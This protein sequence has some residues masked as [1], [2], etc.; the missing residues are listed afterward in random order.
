MSK[1]NIPNFSFLACLEV[2]EKSVVVD[3]GRVGW[4]STFQVT[5]MSNFNLSFIECIKNTSLNL[6]RSFFLISLAT[7]MLEGLDIIHLKDEIHSSV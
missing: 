4:V 5:T 7:C 2:A 3:S 1:V 6:R